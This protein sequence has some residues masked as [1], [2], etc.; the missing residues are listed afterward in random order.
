MIEDALAEVPVRRE[1]GIVDIINMIV[2]EGV[3]TLIGARAAVTR[4][5]VAAVGKE[6]VTDLAVRRDPDADL[7]MVRH[8]AILSMDDQSHALQFGLATGRTTISV[9]STSSGCEI[10]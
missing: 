1:A 6:F 8:G 7:A 4:L 5:V 2:A 9:V 3:S 10:A